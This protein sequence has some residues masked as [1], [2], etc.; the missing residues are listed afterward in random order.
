M[1]SCCDMAEVSKSS[2][3]LSMQVLGSVGERSMESSHHSIDRNVLHAS[4]IYRADSQKAGSALGQAPD[5]L[6]PGVAWQAWAGKFHRGAPHGNHNR[7]AD[8]CCHMHWAGVVGEHHPTQM[9][10]GEQFGEP[11]QSREVDDA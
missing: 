9:Q 5:E 3:R 11:G 8:R 1:S 6:M 2:R 10:P 7:G 4:E